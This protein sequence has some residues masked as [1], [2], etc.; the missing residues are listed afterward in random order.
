M[1]SNYDFAVESVSDSATWI[2]VEFRRMVGSDR[3]RYRIHRPGHYIII[4]VC[5]VFVLSLFFSYLPRLAI[6]LVVY[7]YI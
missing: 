1:R 7:A 5:F 4:L 6:R 2:P 3:A